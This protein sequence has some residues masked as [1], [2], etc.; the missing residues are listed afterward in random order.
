M[1]TSRRP[2]DRASLIA[3][4]L[5]AGA[6]AAGVAA[7][8]ATLAQERE[9]LWLRIDGIQG[10]ATHIDHPNEIALISYS[11]SATRPD[12]GRPTCDPIIVTKSI[13]KASPILIAS[14]FTNALKGRGV[15][16]TARHGPGDPF[17][18]LRV[19]LTGVS[20]D[21][22]TYSTFTTGDP[23]AES[24][25]MSYEKFVIVYTPVRDEQTQGAVSF[26]FDC[27]RA[28]PF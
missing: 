28:V 27:K 12:R 21:S 5:V 18:Y 26:S 25:T 24:V 16:I 7:P 13:D 15:V 14:V 4:A 17:D 2:M 19:Q 20:I 22:V 6:L 1:R 3:W 11:Q 10:E 23:A 8:S 9:R